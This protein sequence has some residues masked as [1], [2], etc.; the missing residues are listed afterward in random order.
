MTKRTNLKPGPGETPEQL[1]YEQIQHLADNLAFDVMSMEGEAGV[2]LMLLMQ[3]IA[4]HPFDNSHVET[5]ANLL[6]TYLFAH[7]SRAGE[8]YKRFIR[9]EYAKFQKGGE[10]R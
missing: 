7:S 1:T 9:E 5:I 4:S 3:D 6:L 8:E 10:G 2:Y